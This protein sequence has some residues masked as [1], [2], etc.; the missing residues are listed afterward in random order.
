MAPTLV[1]QDGAPVLALGSPGGATIICRCFSDLD[2]DRSLPDAGAAPRASQRNGSTT[3]AE[4]A[5][6]A[7]EGAALERYG[8]QFAAVSAIGAVTG[9]ALLGDGRMQAVAEPTRRGGGD[10]RVVRPDGSRR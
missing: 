4:P 9:I 5:F 6:V 7:A 10:A 1:T 8:Q 3:L 2:L